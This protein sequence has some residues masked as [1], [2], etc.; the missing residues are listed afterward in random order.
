MNGMSIRRSTQRRHWLSVLSGSAFPVLPLILASCGGSVETQHPASTSTVH[1]A[2]NAVKSVQDL[3][4]DG[5]LKVIKPLMVSDIAKYNIPINVLGVKRVTYGDGRRVTITAWELVYGGGLGDSFVA[6]AFS[7]TPSSG[8]HLLSYL[9]G[10]IE[11]KTVTGVPVLVKPL[12]IPG[13]NT[14][15]F[16][17]G[18]NLWFSNS[19]NVVNICA[20]STVGPK[21]ALAFMKQSNFTMSYSWQSSN[22]HYLGYKETKN[23]NSCAK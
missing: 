4:V 18:P 6:G 13:T 15:F 14:A 1:V 19:G 23:H 17:L 8:A 7:G 10:S 22:L 11:D 20:R 16:S 21:V 2:S 9:V 12:Q 5:W 3:P